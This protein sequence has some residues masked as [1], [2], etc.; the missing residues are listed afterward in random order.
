[1]AECRRTNAYFSGHVQGVGFRY[2]TR[3]LAENF[4]VTG[5]VRNLADGRVQVVV[6]GQPSEVQ[7]FLS[8]VEDEL[9]QYIQRVDSTEAPASGEFVTFEI[10]A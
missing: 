1:M 10:R 3:R 5:F 7:R 6:E 2:S 8:S 4:N 9:S